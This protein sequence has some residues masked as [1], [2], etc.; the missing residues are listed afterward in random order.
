MTTER[1]RL[2]DHDDWSRN[3]ISLL[4]D[5]VAALVAETG[6]VDGARLATCTLRPAGA[7]PAVTALARGAPLATSAELAGTL[8]RALVVLANTTAASLVLVAV[9]TGASDGG[10]L[11]AVAE[12]TVL[13]LDRLRATG[14][15]GDRLER[16]APVV[17]AVAGAARRVT[18]ARCVDGLVGNTLAVVTVEVATAELVVGAELSLAAATGLGQTLLLRTRTVTRLAVGRRVAAST[19]GL[20]WLRTVG[21]GG[22]N[23]GL[24]VRSTAVEVGVDGGRDVLEQVSVEKCRRSRLRRLQ[25]DERSNGKES[26]GFE[27]GAHGE[28]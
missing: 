10:A 28:G 5:V 25:R 18:T 11:G 20:C 4:A 22:G 1:H 8:L 26:A 6:P 24:S 9:R 12:E 23:G 3:E 2:C 21:G 27:R 7:L 16:L 14:A 19:D 13:T 17:V 15:L